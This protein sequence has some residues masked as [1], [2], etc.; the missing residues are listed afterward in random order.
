LT[1]GLLYYML[2]SNKQDRNTEK[3]PT[4]LNTCKTIYAEDIEVDDELDLDGDEYG[5]NEYAIFNF[6]KVATKLDTYK[7]GEPWIILG[8]SQGSFEMP[9]G[10]TVKVKVQE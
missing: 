10:H 5:D 9:A 4:M 2:H 8:T 3:E 1:V 6:A 7:H